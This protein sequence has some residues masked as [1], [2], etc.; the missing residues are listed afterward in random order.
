MWMVTQDS[1]LAMVTPPPGDSGQTHFPGGF[2]SDAMPRSC[3]ESWM[4][5]ANARRSV[6]PVTFSSMGTFGGT[7]MVC[8]APALVSAIRR[9]Q[10]LLSRQH[11][12]ALGAGVC[13]DSRTVARPHDRVREN[14]TVT[15][16][17]WK[18]QRSDDGDGLHLQREAVSRAPNSDSHTRPSSST[19]IPV[20]LLAASAAFLLPNVY[21]GASRRIRLAET[22]APLTVPMLKQPN[23][24]AS[25]PAARLRRPPRSNARV[26]RCRAP[27]P[28]GGR[29]TRFERRPGEHEYPG[30]WSADHGRFSG[31]DAHWP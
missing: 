6:L 28:R 17:Y 24:V 3:V 7:V 20:A 8:P 12:P 30:E 18:P 26:R 10:A 5:K 19:T 22:G 2:Q 23:S 11:V 29:L 4:T 13:V 31:K 15:V 16:G 21:A 9:F 27:A 14:G 1:V 25:H